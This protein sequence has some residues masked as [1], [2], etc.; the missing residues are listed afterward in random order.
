MER[1]QHLDIHTYIHAYVW[2]YMYLVKLFVSS[3]S[4]SSPV[5]SVQYPPV[6]CYIVKTITYIPKD[7]KRFHLHQTTSSG[8]ITSYLQS[9]AFT[10]F[11]FTDEIHYSCQI[12]MYHIIYLFRLDFLSGHPRLLYL[13]FFFFVVR[14]AIIVGIKQLQDTTPVSSNARYGLSCLSNRNTCIHTIYIYYLHLHRYRLPTINIQFL[15]EISDS[16]IKT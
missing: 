14:V 5:K 11:S 12:I 9:R 6:L 7:M 1:K 4:S 15:S 2:A 10:G 13:F 16:V 8:C 3:I